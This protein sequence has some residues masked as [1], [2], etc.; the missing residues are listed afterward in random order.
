MPKNTLMYRDFSGGENTS[1]N[2]KTI[3]PNELQL[4]SGVMVD[5]QGY[6][7]SFYPPQK[8]NSTE[9]LKDFTYRIHPGRGI[10]YFKSDYSY[11]SGGD[12]KDDGPYHYILISDKK[13]GN[14]SITDGETKTEIFTP[15]NAIFK[16]DFYV[17]NNVVRIGNSDSKPLAGGQ[18]WFG[19]IGKTSNKILL[20]H[21]YLK[22]WYIADNTLNQPLAGIVGRLSSS[23]KFSGSAT[24][25]VAPAKTD[26]AGAATISNN[27]GVVQFN[28]SSHG[29]EDGDTVIIS[30]SEYYSGSHTVVNKATNT[31]E[32]SKTYFGAAEDETPEWRRRSDQDWF[33]GIS[34][35]IDA[36]ETANNNHVIWS[37]IDGTDDELREIDAVDN[38]A[39]TLSVKAASGNA[40]TNNTTAWAIFPPINALNLD[41]YQSRGS[42]KGAWPPGNYEFGHTFVYEEN[43]ESLVTKLIGNDIVID[44]NEVLYVKT[45]ISGLN[46]TSEIPG[47]TLSA[48]IDPRLIGARVY[49]RK[50]GTSDSW[51]LLVDVNLQTTSAAVGGGTRLSLTEKY[52]SFFKRVATDIDTDIWGAGSTTIGANPTFWRGFYS[53]EYTINSPSPFTYDSINGFLQN[54]ASLSFGNPLKLLKYQSSVI[55]GSRTFLANIDYYDSRS[56]QTENSYPSKMG[57]AIVYSPPN[58]MDTFPP[59]NRLDIAEGDG[60]EFT[61]LMESNG[62]LL[63]FKTN[64]LYLID[65]KNSNPASWKLQNK[66]NGLGVQGT[67][68]ATKIESSVA[69]VN[70]FGCWIYDNGKITNL[71]ERKI[72]SSQW[73]SWTRDRFNK[74][75]GIGTATSTTTNKLIDSS[76]T[77]TSDKSDIVVGDI[78]FNETAGTSAKVTAIDSDTQLN[79]SADIFTSNDNFSI[80]SISFGPLIGYDNISKKLIIVNDCINI[81]DSPR[82]YCL[83][84]GAW[85]RGIDTSLDRT[86]NQISSQTPS[87]VGVKFFMNGT[88]HSKYNL[89]NNVWS[90]FITIPN[91]SFINNRGHNSEGAGAVVYVDERS[92]GFINATVDTNNTAG[93]SSSSVFGGNHKVLQIDSTADLT[94]GMQ[95]L[96][97]GIGNLAIID[98]IISSTLFRVTVASTATNNNQTITFIGERDLRWFAMKQKVINYDTTDGDGDAGANRTRYNI[99]TRDEDFGAPNNIK[100]IYG[101]TIDYITESNDSSDEVFAFDINYQINGNLVTTNIAQDWLEIDSSSKIINDKIGVG[102]SLGN[103]VNTISIDHNNFSSNEGNPIRCKS[104][105]FQITNKGLITRSLSGTVSGGGSRQFFKILN[106]GIKYRILGKTSETDFSAQDTVSL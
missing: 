63:A 44:S 52:D 22:R 16:P 78:V 34:E 45:L 30:G 86:G 55:S 72:S 23:I 87:K 77:F 60:D 10:F 12:T 91:S 62:M 97:T 94:I 39:T 40:F 71:I 90:N 41:I 105:A 15:T 11:V 85:T 25:L 75:E 57:D 9:S 20:G 28:S 106:I 98:L 49:T 81:Q 82:F 14:I 104:I 88:E 96:G 18:K 66:F 50:S 26:L 56:Q 17:H 37:F 100:K 51:I 21:T 48:G 2:P 36:L 95:V 89:N 5:E 35:G 93:S 76:G 27:S 84:T 80:K 8:S 24:T 3:K 19:P 42:D 58:K 59:S 46:I 67:H 83:I 29:M 68:S 73:Q 54:E 61:C 103:Q 4:A 1:A 74:Y 43:Q 102:T 64:S 31:F 38:E 6:L 33:G 99:V 13:T 65:I 7:S 101:V 70:K 69:F 32:I 92:N 53:K 47:G 79:L